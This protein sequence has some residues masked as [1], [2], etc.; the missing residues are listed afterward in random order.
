MKLFFH[1]CVQGFSN[2]YILGSD[3]PESGEAALPQEPGPARQETAPQA[4]IID[5]GAMDKGILNFIENNN[6]TL[7]GVLITHEHRTHVRGLRTLKRIYS[8]DIYAANHIILEHRTSRVKDGDTL[9]IG[10]FTVEVITV[11]GHSADSA[12]FKIGRLLFTG[13]ALTAGMVGSTVS[14][15][16][17]TVQMTALRSKIFSLPGDF[18][19]LP[20]HGP[21][22][23]LEAER[24]FNAGV[25]HY[26]E[27]KNRRPRFI[28][29]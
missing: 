25:Q 21:P 11:P 4:I 16:G 18:T 9:R 29:E 20:G 19:V 14:S 8:A 23:T 27:I 1:Y 24:R 5:P 12:V 13:D 2:C 26:E 6:Y 10:P 28:V 3:F 7:Q 15:Y 17:A 22:S